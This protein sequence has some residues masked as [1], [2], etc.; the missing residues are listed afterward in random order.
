MNPYEVLGVSP[1]VSDEELKKAYRN[2]AKKYHPDRYV[3]SPLAESAS[4]KMKQI[5]EAYDIILEQRKRRQ[6]GSTE[7]HTYSR[8]TTPNDTHSVVLYHIREMIGDNR[9]EEAEYMLSEIPSNQRNAEWYYLMGVVTYQKGFL[10]E[11]Y[12][13]FETA[14]RLE[15]QNREYRAF[16]DRVRGN[17]RGDYYGGYHPQSSVWPSCDCC[18]ICT[19]LMCSDCLCDCLNCG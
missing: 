15:P 11:A 16:Y 18:D 4:E 6:S 17:R 12:N 5:N 7:K 3:N 2:L 8:N 10:E 1:D 9:F 14:C 13:Y 19:C